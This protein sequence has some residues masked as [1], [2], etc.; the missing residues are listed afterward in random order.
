MD[1]QVAWQRLLEKYADRDW[2]EVHE[3]ASGLLHW[4]DH[5]GFPPRTTANKRLG[6]EWDRTMARF[7]CLFAL[8]EA[9]KGGC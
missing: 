1:P 4:L 3:V 2:L 5:E 6:E 8:E 7:A 9:K